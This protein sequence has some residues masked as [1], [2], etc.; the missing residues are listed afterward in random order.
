M[1]E[2]HLVVVRVTWSTRVHGGYS[3]INNPLF[4]FGLF[5][6]HSK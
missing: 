5:S 1:I 2:T 3:K 4:P 6:H